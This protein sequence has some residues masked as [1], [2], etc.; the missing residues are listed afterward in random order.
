MSQ[1][2]LLRPLILLSSSVASAAAVTLELLP[3]RRA[4][5]IPI[6]P[7]LRRPSSA[8][9]K[10]TVALLVTIVSFSFIMPMPVSANNTSG[11][12]CNE[13]PESFLRQSPTPTVVG[14]GDPLRV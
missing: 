2:P 3:R 12:C 9:A 5:I 11:F 4:S 13:T 14:S 8:I 1:G 6:R 7:W 10:A